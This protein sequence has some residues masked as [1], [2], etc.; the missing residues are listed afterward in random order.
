MKTYDLTK[1]LSAQAKA[2][3]NRIIETHEKHKNS[4]FFAPSTSAS[5]RRA[6]EKA[7]YKNNPNVTFLTNKG[8][9][10]VE[11]TYNETCSTVYY[12]CNIYQGGVKKTITVIKS[13]L[14]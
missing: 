8:G 12:S 5:G 7:F 9:V 13:L 2:E 1:R 3:L 14:K 11:M 10:G 6:K 4:Y